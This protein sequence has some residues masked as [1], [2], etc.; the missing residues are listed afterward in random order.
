MKA[1]FFRHGARIALALMLI[2]GTLTIPGIA[3]EDPREEA[4]VTVVS[5]SSL[6]NSEYAQIALTQW[7]SN[8]DNVQILPGVRLTTSTGQG[9]WVLHFAAGTS[10]TYSIYVHHGG[11]N[12][13]Y[14]TIE[15]VAPTDDSAVSWVIGDGGGHYASINHIKL[16]GEGTPP[17]EP[18]V[19]VITIV[20]DTDK[21]GEFKFAVT[22]GDDTEYVPLST[23]D[24]TGTCSLELDEG[25]TGTVS[26]SEVEW[27]NGDSDLDGWIFDDS[28]YEFEFADGELVSPE[29]LNLEASFENSYTESEEPVEPEISVAKKA[30]N[31]G[32]DGKITS[33][34]TVEYEVIVENTGDEAITNVVVSDNRFDKVTGG[35]GGIVVSASQSGDDEGYITL[36]EE[37]DYSFVEN[38]GAISIEFAEGFKLE[39]EGKIKIEYKIAWTGAGS[40]KNVVS[41]TGEGVQSEDK[42]SGSDD[43]TV[44][45]PNSSNNNSGGKT[46]PRGGGSTTISDPPAPLAVPDDPQQDDPPA[47]YT[48][49][50]D[51]PPVSVPL[52]DIPKTGLAGLAVP[53]VIAGVSLAALLA[54]FFSRKRETK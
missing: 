21:D 10:G 11:G 1:V 40:Y 19:P 16:G 49:P 39:V 44:T 7:S 5:V 30:T 43:V 34:Q 32:T 48:P 53:F 2:V 28:V 46:P 17:I 3:F 51:I 33:G 25:F 36:V 45:I 4:G 6:T 13:S 42:V 37:N 12:A 8:S 38:E 52:S 20:K 24:G 22:I 47:T 9:Q 14:V 23:M 54:V 18:D 35:T 15:V 50:A 31:V 41:V 29:D 26:I 27:F